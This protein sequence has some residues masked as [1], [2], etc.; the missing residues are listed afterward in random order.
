MDKKSNLLFVCYGNS[1]RS[2]M[3]EGWAHHL[4]PGTLNAF[5]AG[6]EPLGSTP[7]QSRS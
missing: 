5:S 3:A 2:Q 7:W 1:C 4:Y 6:I